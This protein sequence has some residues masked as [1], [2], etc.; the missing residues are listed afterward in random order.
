MPENY[1]SVQQPQDQASSVIVTS[2][3]EIKPVNK[4][5]FIKR[6]LNKISHLNRKRLL[7]TSS[8]ILLIITAGLGY[9]Y[10]FLRGGKV[11][12]VLGSVSITAEKKDLLGVDPTSAFIIKSKEGLNLAALKANLRIKP[13]S[14]Y[15]IKRVNDNEFR[16]TFDQPLAENK[17]YQFELSTEDA[18]VASGSAKA[19]DLSWAFQIKTSFRIVHT[20]PRD[21]ATNVPLNSGIEL[22]FSHENY[23]D[24]KPSSEITPHVDGRFEKHKRVAV[25]VP[26]SLEPETLYTV[27]IKKGIKL[28]G[29]QESLKEDFTFQFETASQNNNRDDIYFGFSHSLTE[30]PVNEKPAFSLYFYNTEKSISLD[31][32]VYKFKDKNQ[33]ID[34]LKEKDKIPQW[35]YFY[36]NSYLYDS[37]NLQKLISFSAPVQNF[38]FGGYFIF[39]QALVSVYYLVDASYN[40]KTFQSW[41][42]ITDVATYLATSGTKT[43]AWVN[44]V[45]T[46]SSLKD[47]TLKLISDGSSYK[48]NDQGAAYFDTPK[49][50]VNSDKKD[51]YEVMAANGKSAI[52]PVFNDQRNYSGSYYYSDEGVSSKSE[53]YWSYLYLDRPVYLPTDN[54]N[55][56]GIV[57]ERDNPKDSQKLKVS[58]TTSDYYDYYFNPVSIFEQE[59][60]ASDQGT[61]TGSIPLKNLIPGWYEVDIRLDEEIIVRGSFNV[62]TYTKPAYKIELESGKKAVFAGETVKFTGKAAFFE[63]TAVPNLSLNYNGSQVGKVKTDDKGEFIIN[64]NTSYDGSGYG[65]YYPTHNSIYAVPDLTEEGEIEGGASVMVFGPKVV[66]HTEANSEGNQGLV[67]ITANKITLDRINNSTAKSDQDYLGDLLASAEIKG[68]IYETIWEKIEKGEIYD[69]INKT[70]TKTYDY[71]EVK[72]K[73][74]DISV[75][76]NSS[77]DAVV[78]FPIADDKYYTVELEL[79]DGEG[80]ISKESR[81]IYGKMGGYPWGSSSDYSHLVSGKEGEN[82]YY[83]VDDK[84]ELTMMKGQDVELPSGG[85]N[86][87]LFRLAQRGLRSFKI[88]DSPKFEF[89]FEKDYIPNIV[90]KAVYFNGK[91]YIESESSS[92]IFDRQTKKLDIK[93]GLDKDSYKPRDDVK[94]DVEVTDN[95]GRGQKGEVNLSLVDEAI[96]KISDQSVDT[97]KDI[98]TTLN[99]GIISTY[100]S[101]QYPSEYS[102]AEGGGCFLDGTKILIAN[103]K[104]RNIEEIKPGDEVVTRDGV[105]SAK[106]VSAKVIKTYKHSVGQYLV[107][108]DK[109]RVTTEHNLFV[110]GRFMIAGDIK[111]GDSLLNS[112]NKWEPVFSIERQ[113][114]KFTVYNLEIKDKSTFFAEDYYVHNQKGRELFAD[115]AYFGSVKTNSDGK[116]SA[117][118]K[119][120]D[121]LTSWRITY[122]AISEDMGAGNGTKPLYVKLPFFVDVVG[123]NEYLS[124][125]KPVIKLRSFGEELKE[126][127][128]VQFTVKAP[129]LGIGEQKFN[130]KAFEIAEFNLSN[131]SEGEHKITIKIG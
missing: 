62:E 30:F 66:M 98:Y 95:N 9:W 26:K 91:I 31:V 47:A 83:K 19:R 49:S 124:D 126:G 58:L 63:G 111:V 21:K 28:D 114:G 59:I 74:Q 44:D 80:R 35:T 42:Q 81:F 92:V 76:T 5:N 73:I 25:F 7:I 90:A 64:L 110:N 17:I 125:D 10:F 60:T 4:E 78:Q 67:K 65:Y 94:L 12:V 108:N 15:E 56:W 121:N 123:S 22:T 109:L 96:F 69:F 82:S 40:N 24:I 129:S 75:I 93:I 120:P 68:R 32:N 27:K 43:L 99:S 101:H 128:D 34:S 116:G 61:F 70:T 45:S 6:L 105:K 55:Y 85:E 3:P 89:N 72:N 36:N 38:N 130:K 51:Y 100:L 112:K 57:R 79:A 113:F 14:A 16:L 106:L 20:L 2:A 54:V 53:K 88:S 102:P 39:P 107:I 50:L 33:F 23:S 131:L 52:V 41:L 87:Y 29:S 115:L 13:V 117:N 46:K 103:G 97:L 48:T 1:T 104:T 11:R 77:G 84:V 122:Q 118:F 8:L 18:E 86:K 119:L 37:S 71:K 127:A